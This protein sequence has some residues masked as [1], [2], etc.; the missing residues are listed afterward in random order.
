MASLTAGGGGIGAC[1]N[2]TDDVVVVREVRLAVLAAVDALR[3]EVDVVRE[4]H[5]C[6]RLGREEPWWLED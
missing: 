2:P 5:G 1:T 6:T 4:A 3:V